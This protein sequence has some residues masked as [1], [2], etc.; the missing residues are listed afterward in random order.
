MEW[1]DRGYVD[2]ALHGVW[3]EAGKAV[4]NLDQSQEV[5]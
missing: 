1:L 2:T 4:N 3:H 5:L